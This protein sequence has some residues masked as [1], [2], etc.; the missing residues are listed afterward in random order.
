MRMAYFVL[1]AVIAGLFS[2]YVCVSVY[3]SRRSSSSFCQSLTISFSV[4]HSVSI[5]NKRIHNA[6][7][8]HFLRVLISRLESLLVAI[9]LTTSR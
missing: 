8:K 9:K 2:F 3:L 5:E 4:I 6:T 1:F 7:M